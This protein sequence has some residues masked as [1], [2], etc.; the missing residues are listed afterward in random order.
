MNVKRCKYKRLKYKYNK[1][2]DLVVELSLKL[3]SA[4]QTKVAEFEDTNKTKYNYTY[5]EQT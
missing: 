3:S 5:V 2:L 4:E 1:L